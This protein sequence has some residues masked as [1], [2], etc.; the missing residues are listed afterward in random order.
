[1][2]VLSGQRFF[3]MSALVEHSSTQKDVRNSIHAP[4]HALPHLPHVAQLV[5]GLEKVAATHHVGNYVAIRG[6]DQRIFESM[7]LVTRSAP[8]S[9]Q[10]DSTP[11]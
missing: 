6:S 11:R 3:M 4:W 1:M 2:L 9:V 8:V 10:R 5:P 7:P